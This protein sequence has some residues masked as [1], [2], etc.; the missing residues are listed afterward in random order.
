[1]A[2]G[3]ERIACCR[4]V[5]EADEPALHPLLLAGLELM[6]SLAALSSGAPE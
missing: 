2:S 3:W 1:M 6:A 4:P 5:A